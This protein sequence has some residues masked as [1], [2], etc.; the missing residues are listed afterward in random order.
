MRFEKE[1][2]SMGVIMG[3]IISQHTK[4]KRSAAATAL[5]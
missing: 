5:Q 3:A 1:S 4:Q 2:E